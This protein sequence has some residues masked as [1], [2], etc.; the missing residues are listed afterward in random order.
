MSRIDTLSFRRTIRISVFAT[1]LTASAIVQSG[2]LKSEEGSSVLIIHEPMPGANKALD[3]FTLTIRD[4]KRLVA[5]EPTSGFLLGTHWSANGKY[6]AVNN[7]RGNSG[8]Y[9]WIFSFPDGRCLKRPDD[10]V[11]REWEIAAL[12]E[13]AVK[14]KGADSDHLDR[15]WLTADGWT[16]AGE[17][18]FALRAKYSGVG[19]FTCFGLAEI[20]DG[21]LVLKSLAMAKLE[22]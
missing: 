18:I 22:G 9:L 15:D 21:R 10:E 1:I 5:S 13:I 4:G 3:G 7:R 12:R 8:D 14:N 17:L 19:T 6:V 20:K 16:P 11:G 2:E